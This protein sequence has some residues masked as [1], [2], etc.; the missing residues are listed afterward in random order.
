[1]T[2]GRAQVFAGLSA[3]SPAPTTAPPLRQSRARPSADVVP[4]AEIN[5]RITVLSDCAARFRRSLSQRD[6]K[7]GTDMAGNMDVTAGPACAGARRRGARARRRAY[8]RDV[9]RLGEARRLP[10]LCGGS[11]AARRAGPH[12][13][14]HHRRRG[15][16]ARPGLRSADRSD[17]AGRGDA[18]AAN[19]GAL[20][21]R[22]RRQRPHRVRIV[23]RQLRAGDPHA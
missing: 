21:R 2:Y 6:P 8:E 18:A 15:T 11:H 10:A 16:R 13:G 19:A 17:R 20:L 1:M 3:T 23:A 22:T 5:A 7:R 14:L 12:Q 4:C 9:S